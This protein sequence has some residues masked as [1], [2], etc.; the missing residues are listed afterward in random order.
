MR[1]SAEAG[2][3]RSV[4]TERGGPNERELRK[5]LVGCREEATRR[6]VWPAP[7]PGRRPG[8]SQ[9]GGAGGARALL[10]PRCPVQPPAVSRFS[11]TQPAP[12]LSFAS[13]S[14]ASRPV[15]CQS[16]KTEGV[17]TPFWFLI[18]GLAQELVF[19]GLHWG[20]FGLPGRFGFLKLIHKEKDS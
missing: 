4:M 7:E 15:L 5:P 12:H 3:V 1:H 14:R 8:R 10:A 11:L 13:L 17:H 18:T 6:T 19:R 20:G 2:D 9:V 16:A